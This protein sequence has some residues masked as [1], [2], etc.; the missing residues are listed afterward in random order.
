MFSGGRDRVHW[1]GMGEHEPQIL[2]QKNVIFLWYKMKIFRKVFEDESIFWQA[3]D[4]SGSPFY[5]L[6]ITPAIVITVLKWTFFQ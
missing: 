5:V 3:F 4:L 1:E 6:K 2:L